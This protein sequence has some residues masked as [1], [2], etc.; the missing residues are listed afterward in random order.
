MYLQVI[1]ERAD[2]RAKST[3]KEEFID[4]FRCIKEAAE[5]LIPDPLYSFDNVSTQ[6]YADLPALGITNSQ[7]M[8]LGPN[9]PADW[10]MVH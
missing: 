8:P 4:Q 6:A 10:V 1:K 3:T 7:R 5:K 2:R 9:M